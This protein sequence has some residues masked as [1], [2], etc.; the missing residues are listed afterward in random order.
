MDKRTDIDES[1]ERQFSS[2][3]T[4]AKKRVLLAI[5]I[6]MVAAVVLVTWLF[7]EGIHLL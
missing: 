2:R 7:T 6:L 3:L 1:A 5:V 4:T